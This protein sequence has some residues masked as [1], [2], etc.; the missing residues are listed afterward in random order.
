MK[1]N[2]I[3]EDYANDK[4]LINEFHNFISEVFPSISFK[5]WYLKGFWQ[6]NYIP[7]SIIESGKIISNVCV[8][9]MSLKLNGQKINAI[10]IGA[11]GTLPEYRNKG[12]S[13]IL[14]NY[15]LDKYEKHTDLFFLF[16]NET[17][18][19]FY[20]KFGFSHVEER[21][22]LLDTNIPKSNDSA[23]KLN[24]NIESDY[25]ILLNLV[26]N[27]MNLS[28]KFGA[29]EYGSI[30]MWHVLNLHL[31]DLY[32]LEEEDIIIIKMEK[33][34]VLHIFD[35]IFRTSFDFQIVLPKIISSNSVKIIKYYFSPDQL[36]YKYNKTIIDDSGLFIRGEF[37]M[38][39]ELLKFPETAHT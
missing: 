14:M 34:N 4:N 20:P 11:V 38:S 19:D 21:I 9:V 8:A 3:I 15:V 25:N 26:N 16:A 1:E 29:E 5:D 12:L 33:D 39:G 10:Q 7:Y 36:N 23:R 30:T 28:N 18:M 24:I 2:N 37:N 32:Y 35:V 17:V 31:V 6:K 27:R 22:F 13:R